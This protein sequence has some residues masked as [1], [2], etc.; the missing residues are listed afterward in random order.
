[1]RLLHRIFIWLLFLLTAIYPGG[2]TL[3]VKLGYSLTFKCIPAFT[4]VLAVLSVFLVILGNKQ[5]INSKL[6]QVVI[7]A[8]TPLS[9]INALFC[10]V[11]SGKLMTLLCLGVYVGTVCVLTVMH[12][13]PLALKISTL[14]I[15]FLLALPLGLVLLFVS[16]FGNFGKNTVIQTLES[17]SSEYYAQ[18]ID[19]DQ[20]ALGGDTY[21]EVYEKCLV[22]NFLIRIQ[23]EP[24]R[25]YSGEWGEYAHMEIYWICDDC[26]VIN[27]AEYMI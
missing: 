23:K 4:L 11:A 3:C 17:P 19:S 21:V 25:V 24:R 10:L 16:L 1:M 27:S 12:V 18:V 26:L 8:V 2:K 5:K 6:L 13:T 15:S 22:D 14:S 7:A 20:G 9:L